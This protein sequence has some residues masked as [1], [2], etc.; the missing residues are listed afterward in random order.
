MGAS[1]AYHRERIS[2]LVMIFVK[3]FIGCIEDALNFLEN[4][5]Q[6]HGSNTPTWSR[7]GPPESSNRDAIHA[8]TNYSLLRPKNKIN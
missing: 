5:R 4:I 1:D 6:D 8:N 7:V 3:A 2:E